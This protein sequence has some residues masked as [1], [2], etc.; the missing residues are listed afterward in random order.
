MHRDS[1]FGRTC[2]DFSISKNVSRR[3]CHASTFFWLRSVRDNGGFRDR[4]FRGGLCHFETRLTSKWWGWA[5]IFLVILSLVLFW[6]DLTQPITCSIPCRL[7]QS[8]QST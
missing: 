7:S 6:Q 1:Y 2:S 8:L 4:L 3:F 5:T